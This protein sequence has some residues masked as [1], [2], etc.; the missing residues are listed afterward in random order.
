MSTVLEGVAA[1]TSSHETFK[2]KLEWKHESGY[3]YIFHHNDDTNREFM[4]TVLIF[5]V[6]GPL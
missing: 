4:L 2:R 6:P 1:E 3:R 5:D